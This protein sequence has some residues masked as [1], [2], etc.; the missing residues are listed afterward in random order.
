MGTDVKPLAAKAC[1]RGDD[2]YID[3]KTGYANHVCVVFISPW[4]RRLIRLFPSYKV[5]TEDAHLRRGRC[6][7]SVCRHCPFGHIAVKD[8]RFRTA[9]I[10]KPTFI[11]LSPKSKHA[12]GQQDVDV[13]FWSGV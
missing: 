7:A 2:I 8:E 13:L 11:S 9:I 10:S 6:C 5:F 1:H 3:P 4:R 12:S